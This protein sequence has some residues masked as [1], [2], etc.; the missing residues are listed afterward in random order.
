[1]TFAAITP[2]RSRVRRDRMKFSAWA[3]FVPIWSLIV[4]TPVFYWVYVGWHHSKLDPAAIDFA[5]GTA[6]HINAGVAA[7]ALVMVLGKR[8]GWPDGHAAPQ[9]ALRHARCRHPLVRVVRL[10]WRF[11]LCADG[12]AAQA[13]LNTFVA[14]SRHGRLACHRME[15]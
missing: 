1:M 7:L 15:A 2:A 10:Q 4:Y 13:V 14:G 9:P 5:G 3:I 11:G 12:V 6:I 8:A